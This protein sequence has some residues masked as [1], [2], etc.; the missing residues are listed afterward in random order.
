MICPLCHC[1]YWYVVFS[2]KMPCHNTHSVCGICAMTLHC[3]HPDCPYNYATTARVDPLPA[4]NERT[5]QATA[6]ETDTDG[7]EA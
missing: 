3:D 4:T 6:P 7:Q 1:D 2:P 5:E